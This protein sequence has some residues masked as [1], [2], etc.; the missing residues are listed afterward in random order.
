MENDA[1]VS[2]FRD[3]SPDKLYRI[4]QVVGEKGLIPISPSNWYAKIAEGLAP[5]PVKIGARV[6]AWRGSDLIAYING[7]PVAA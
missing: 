1:K 6:S 4:G 3:I 7:L 5:K 2:S